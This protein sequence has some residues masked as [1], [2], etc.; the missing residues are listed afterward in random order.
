MMS[1]HIEKF[2]D[3]RLVTKSSNSE[4]NKQQN[5]Q[6]KKYKRINYDR[7]ST[8]QKTKDRVTNT[9]LTIG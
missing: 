1:F 6:R 7:Q 5:D 2:D 8:T 9:T 4:R 3:I